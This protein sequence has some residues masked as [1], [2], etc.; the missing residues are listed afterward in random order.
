MFYR[1]KVFFTKLFSKARK[2]Y[3]DI[4]SEYFFR[5]R[6]LLAFLS[7]L[8]I[9]PIIILS[10]RLYLYSTH[11]VPLNGGIY[12]EGM[13]GQPK[14]INPLYSSS[15]LPDRALVSLIY[16]GLTKI[17]EKGNIVPDAAE[18]W[19][20]KD[21]GKQIIFKLRKNLKWH[22]GEPF[23]SNDIMY[24]IS[25]IQDPDYTGPLKN[26]WKDINVKIPDENTIIFDLPKAQPLFIYNTNLGI[27]P[28]HTWAGFEIADL[29]YIEQNLKPIGSGKF[30][31][32]DIKT[33]EKNFIK[34]VSLEKNNEYYGEKPFIDAINFNFYK[35]S[36][37]TF[38]AL[39]KKE[40]M[41]TN[42][43]TS[44]NYSKIKDWKRL[45]VSSYN[46]P[47]YKGIFINSSKNPLFSSID[48][49]NA[50]NL[51]ADREKLVTEKLNGMA[52]VID[53]MFL[54][55]NPQNNF[56]L[57]KAKESLIKA[58]LKDENNDGFFEKDGKKIELKLSIADDKE[59]NLV[60]ESL[61]GDWAKL[62]IVLNIEKKNIA[63]LERD[64]IK[65]RNYEL[66]FFGQNYGIDE[67]LFSFWHS[68]QQKD[69]GL[70]LTNF[71]SKRVDLLLESAKNIYDQ[72]KK[73]EIDQKVEELVKND[74]VCIFLYSPVFNFATDKQ[75]KG[76]KK[77]FLTYPEHRFMDIENWYIRS[78]RVFR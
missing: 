1:I 22:D 41:S 60:A 45:K 63:E 16:S 62:G 35:N 50:L 20:V 58:G 31:L 29:P 9:I 14:T 52:V 8:I 56:D 49:R 70:N 7:L 66:L 2:F 27:L 25:V 34:S 53:G 77:H 67:D 6:L 26:Q 17:D 42:D 75:V 19:E 5:E 33:D 65:P 11:E 3:S 78:K 28:E 73:K 68:T 51:S 15:N 37:E 48:F 76:I 44:N 4:F 72:S 57:V 39:T 23:L 24:T 59:S 38:D 30:K 32:K 69:P 40:I 54:K 64:V 43:I 46:L 55:D 18:N 10:V 61:K 36:E 71:S 13:T 12:I 74:M 21:G 47:I